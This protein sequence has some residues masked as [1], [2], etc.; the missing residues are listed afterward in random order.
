MPVFEAHFLSIPIR[1]FSGSFDCWS[2]EFVSLKYLTKFINTISPGSDDSNFNIFWPELTG[3]NTEGLVDTCSEKIVLICM[4]MCWAYKMQ[5]FVYE[6]QKL[7]WGWHPHFKVIRENLAS[8]LFSNKNG[9][10][11]YKNGVSF[12]KKIVNIFNNIWPALI[13]LT[14]LM[15][16]RRHGFNND[17]MAYM[18]QFA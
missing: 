10:I 5:K 1:Y 17:V 16:M 7:S 6:L 3:T 4:G 11:S 9:R 13:T 18:L 14:G 15:T 12:V 8:L 2:K